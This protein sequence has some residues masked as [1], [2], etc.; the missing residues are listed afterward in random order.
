MSKFFHK[1]YARTT[2]LLLLVSAGLIAN[3]QKNVEKLVIYENFG[4]VNSSEMS[5][6]PEQWPAVYADSGKQSGWYSTSQTIDKTNGVLVPQFYGNG[7]FS[8]D[9][10]LKYRSA[11]TPVGITI[12]NVAKDWSKQITLR[13]GYTLFGTNP[14]SLTFKAFGIASMPT[15][16][17]W[18]MY[19]NYTPDFLKNMKDE[20]GYLYFGK[21]VGTTHPVLTIPGSITEMLKNVCKIE[22]LISGSRLGQNST[23]SVAVQELS[24][25][26]EDKGTKYYTFSASV[27]PRLVSFS[28]NSTYCRIYIQNWGSA[29]NANVMDYALLTSN[30]AKD[31]VPYNYNAIACV[32]PDGTTSSGQ[33]SN[34]GL[35]LHMIKIYAKVSGTGYNVTTNSS[36]VSGTTSGIGYGETTTLTAN[37]SNNGKKFMGWK[38]SGRDDLSEVVN[39]LTIIVTKDMEI[40]PVY[41]GDEV[42]VAVVNENF[43]NW[44]QVGSVDA[45]K[46]NLLVYN[47]EPTASTTPSLSVFATKSVRVPLRYGYTNRGKDSVNINL[48]KCLVTPHYGLRVYNM[49][50]ADS[51]IGYVAFMGPKDGKGYVTVDSL[52]QI[53]KVKVTLSSIDLP[54]PDRACIVKVNGKIERSKMLQTLYAQ[55]L[56]LTPTDTVTNLQVG[57]GGQARCEYTSP[58]SATVD[59][60]SSSVSGAAI[61]MHNLKM[62]S[63]IIMPEFDYY[64]L[65]I[66]SAT[67]GSVY[68]VAPKADNSSNHYPSGAK[69]T[70]SALVN[71]N[72]GFDG[73]KDGNGTIIGT[74]NPITITMDADKT[75]TPVFSQYPSY[76]NISSNAKGSVTSDVSPISVSG[77]VQQFLAGVSVKFTATPKY[78]YNFAKW[79]KNG[80]EV[81]TNPLVLSG[82]ELIKNDTIDI[83]V[84]YDSITTRQTLA[85]ACDLTKGSVSFNH[86][87]ED[88]VVVNDTIKVKFPTGVTIIATANDGYG[89]TFSNWKGGLAVAKSDTLSPSVTLTISKDT[90]IAVLWKALGR[91]LL[92]VNQGEH[93]TVSISDSHKDGAQEQQGLWPINYNVSLSV[94]P[95]TGYELS[96]LGSN[97]NYIVKDGAVTINMD[98]DTVIV[99]PIFV[100][101]QT[102]V[103]E[104]VNENFQDAAKW[105][106]NAGTVSNVPGAIAFL[107]EN[108]SANLSDNWNPT[109]YNSNLNALLKILAPYRVWGSATGGSDGPNGSANPATTL[110]LQYNASVYSQKF[111]AGSD[112]VK[113][114]LVNYAPCNNCLIGKAVKE[115]YIGN[116]YLG[117]VT[118]GMIALRR[119]TTTGY[120]GTGTSAHST[121]PT[122]DTTSVFVPG[123]QMG[124]MLIEGLAYVKN[125]TIGFVS[126]ESQFAPS[127]YYNIEGTTLIEENGK[128]AA[129]MADLY[130]IGEVSRKAYRPEDNRYGW[131]SS[132][133]GMIMDQNMYI[134]EK[135]VTETKVLITCGSS[136]GT[137]NSVEYYVYSDVYI[138]DLKIWGSP[139]NSTDVKEAFAEGGTGQYGA[140]FSMLG[141][142]N[143]LMINAPENIDA[144][145]VYNINGKAVKVLKNLDSKLI[146]LGNLR[147]GTYA[148]QAY[149]VS[150]ALYKGSFVKLQ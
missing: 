110:S 68:G 67:G 18:V 132:Q 82:T 138:H 15:F 23:V 129:T 56:T 128:F 100:V 78:G 113:I 81:T 13:N 107:N 92:I 133:Q 57:P 6:I 89:Y 127:V 34:Q 90:T 117:Q 64:K 73:W 37:A 47:N 106:E 87:P 21:N 118:P 55:T 130:Q 17:S 61:A 29:N 14:S 146:D 80:V 2:L 33:T 121:R 10:M 7:F 65:T 53:S 104:V 91:K 147:P 94:Q 112:S 20:M 122:E 44:S 135:D 83:S 85:V 144:I 26:Y 31:T 25:D 5:I 125:L 86:T 123:D 50:G 1:A 95:E 139:M 75:I 16:R 70:I 98:R 36:L 109:I 88:S 116:K 93:G 24:S 40:Y 145:V 22:L 59:V 84:Q 45:T 105:P 58:A 42:L 71:S 150:G 43:T 8:V 134:A 46:N 12:D 27:E 72:Y 69:V 3:A 19:A 62:Y 137:F 4:G 108:A 39:P 114:S 111:K 140:K 74:G 54:N 66:G 52:K 99:S 32:K 131:G 149:G 76:I 48:V 77:N 60:E 28:V 141:T 142:T 30:T 120:T 148:A 41:A 63:K 49:P 96:S 126:K 79:V 101:Q 119:P 51:L 115:E 143:T 97:C 124:M 9:S 35:S 103:I 136:K 102:D 11:G 38:I